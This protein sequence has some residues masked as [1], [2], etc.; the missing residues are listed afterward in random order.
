MGALGRL[1]Q[2]RN[3]NKELCALIAPRENI[4]YFIFLFFFGSFAFSFAFSF[5]FS[6][7]FFPPPTL[8]GVKGGTGH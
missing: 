5:S 8:C 1:M 4:S 7:T 2:G 3:T 6:F